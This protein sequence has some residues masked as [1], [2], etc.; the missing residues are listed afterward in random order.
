MSDIKCIAVF[1]GSGL[2]GRELIAAASRKGLRVRALYRPGSEPQNPPH[3]LEAV[4][5]QLSSTADI[6]RTL[7]GAD[8]AVIVFGPRL[9]RNRPADVFCAAATANIIAEMKR[10]GIRRLVCQTGAMAGGDVPNWSRMV[11]SFVRSYRKNFPA[12]DAD[13]DAQEVKVKESGLDWTLAKP[14]RIS[15]AKRR[16][17]V[18]TGLDLRIGMFTSVRR[19][20]LSD[21]LVSEVTSGRFH[22]KATYVIT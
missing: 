9:K 13:R 4:T 2:T 21:F 8:A 11:R 18:R 19:G 3:G 14:F 12:V 6:G 10:L 17:R 20:D 15:G 5:G 22:G 1:G 7:E 16:G